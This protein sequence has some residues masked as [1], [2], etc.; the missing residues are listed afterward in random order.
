MK[1]E[2]ILVR[3]TVMSTSLPEN[4]RRWNLDTTSFITT[5]AKQ[6]LTC[7]SFPL[8]FVLNKSYK[9]MLVAKCMGR[10]LIVAFL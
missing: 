5:F 2:C 8:S 4:V 10:C 6:N 7:R 9:F 3:I 1:G